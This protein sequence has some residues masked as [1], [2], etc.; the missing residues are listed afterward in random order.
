MTASS[1]EPDYAERLRTKQ[2]AWWKRVLD[3]QMP[4]RVHIRRQQ[5]GFVLD[6]GCG[7]GRSLVNLGGASAGVG[8]DP[9]RDAVETCRARGLVAY[10]PEEFAASPFAQPGRFDALLVAHVLEHLTHAAAIALITEYLPYVR[11]GGRAM[12]ITP[13]EAGYRS[14]PTHVEFVDLSRLDELARAADLVPERA[15]SFPFP[16]A[17][18]KV[19]KYNEFVLLARKSG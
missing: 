8:V 13:Q 4:Y 18:G 10:T 1:V 15:Y 12:L 17:L 2:G 7:I 6:V 16:R 14:D 3:V 11:A 9:N 5:L 19:F